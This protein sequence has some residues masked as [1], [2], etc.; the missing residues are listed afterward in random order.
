MGKVDTI[1]F[2]KTGTLTYGKLAV[3]DVIP[4]GEIDEKELVAI[5]ASEGKPQRASAR[6]SDRRK[7]EAGWT[8]AL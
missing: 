2:D 6:Q 5:A 1:A 8:I 4:I 7:S 3:S